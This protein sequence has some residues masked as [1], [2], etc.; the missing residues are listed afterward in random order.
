[1]KLPHEAELKTNQQLFP[2]TK[3]RDLP[4]CLGFLNGLVTMSLFEQEYLLWLHLCINTIYGVHGELNS[5]T[6]GVTYFSIK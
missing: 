3:V 1:M 6:F 4:N 2:K 5:F